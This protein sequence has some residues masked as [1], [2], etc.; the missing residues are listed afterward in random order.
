[1]PI[2]YV[3]SNSVLNSASGTSTAV[4]MPTATA[5]GNMIYV[6]IASVANSPVPTAPGGWTMVA[7]FTPGTTTTT[8]L[9]R[10]V[11][12][13]GDNS[14]T[15][16]WTWSANGRNLGVAVAYSGVD[17]SVSTNA[18]QVW[19][20]DVAN[21]SITAAS[22][23]ASAGD[24][25]V[26]VGVGRENPGTATTKDWSIQT[27]TDAQRLDIATGGLAT[28]IKL[29]LGWFDSNAGVAAGSTARTVDITPIQQASHVWSI[30]LPLPAGEGVG[31]NPWTH[32]GRPLR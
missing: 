7:S 32:M 29:S 23:G 19:T 16:T 10:K 22:L 13:S 12:V 6:M 28:D 8:Y 3:G 11:A 4:P 2:A 24:W 26:T 31:G 21:A 27:G 9:Y 5:V 18:S 25:L 14:A 17:S 1:M 30:L 15:Y 20:H